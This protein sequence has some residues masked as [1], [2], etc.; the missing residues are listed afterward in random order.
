M[1]VLLLYLAPPTLGFV[2][3]LASKRRSVAVACTVLS[4]IASLSG[5]VFG[6]SAD[7]DTPALGGA[8]LFAVY[9]GAPFAGSACLGVALARPKTPHRPRVETCRRGDESQ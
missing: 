1:T 8:I 9:L 4:L 7:S 3:G 2:L 6:W 5:W